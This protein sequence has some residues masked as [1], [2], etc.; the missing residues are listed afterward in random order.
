MISRPAS[1]LIPSP[2]KHIWLQAW[3]T[4]TNGCRWHIH[5]ILRIEGIHWFSHIEDVSIWRKN[6]S[7]D[8]LQEECTV[9]LPSSQHIIQRL[10]SLLRGSLDWSL[11]ALVQKQVFNHSFHSDGTSAL[12]SV[13]STTVSYITPHFAPQ[14]PFLCTHVQPSCCY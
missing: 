4:R 12:L 8:L 5:D 1:L 9:L 10:S 3:T 11:S 7:S 13:T 6:T 2:S 14:R